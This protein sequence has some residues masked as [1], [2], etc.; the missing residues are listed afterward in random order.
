MR[1]ATVLSEIVIFGIQT[2]GML[3]NRYIHLNDFSIDA[4]QSLSIM[5]L[6]DSHHHLMIKYVR[7]RITDLNAYQQEVDIDAEDDHE[8]HV[9]TKAR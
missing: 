5:I 7:Q 3:A 1:N 6:G 9:N 4:H 2:N 8:P